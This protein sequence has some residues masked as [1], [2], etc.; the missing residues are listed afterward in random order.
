MDASGKRRVFV[1]VL[2]E[3]R[4]RLGTERLEKTRHQFSE[5]EYVDGRERK[6]LGYGEAR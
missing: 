3:V 2:S 1:A 6:R 4:E 5:V